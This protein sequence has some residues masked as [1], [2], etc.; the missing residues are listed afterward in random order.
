M[1]VAFEPPE[2]DALLDLREVAAAAGIT[3]ATARA[4]CLSGRLPSIAGPA[5][6]PLVMRSDLDLWL[7][8]RGQDGNRMR[9]LRD[10]KAGAEALRRLA[11][12][13]SGQLDL[14]ALF[15]DVIAD[16]MDL[17]SLARMGLWLY[18]ANRSNPFSLAAQHG[19]TDEI[20][21]WVSSLGA[22]APAAGVQAIQTR[23]VVTLADTLL[24]TPTDDVR[25][26]YRRNGIRSVCFAPMIFRDE[27]LGLLVLYQDAVHAW[28]DEETALARGIADQVAT[29]VGNARLNDSVRGLAARLEA[30]QELAVRLNRTRGLAEIGDLII[31]GTERLI[32][33]DSIRVYRIDH[34]AGMCVP[35][36]FRGQFGGSRQPDP[37]VL[38]VA[39]GQG[40]TGWVAEQNETVVT[41]D[42]AADPRSVHRFISIAPESML[43]V[44]IS[45]EDH[46]HG[47]IAVSAIG[48]DRFG[49]QDETTLTIF[50]SYAAQAIVHANQLDQ[51]DRQHRELEHQLASQRRLLEI[52]ERLIS[53]RDPKGILEMI[54]DSLRAIVPYDSM[55][56]YRCDFEAGVRRAVVARDRF[57]EVILD[58]A[59]P[60]AGGLSGWVVAHGEG[61]LVNDAL[62]DPRSIQVPGTPP[63][64][65]AMI[66]V[67]VRVAGAVVG[68]LNVSR[69]GGEEAHFSQN[70]FEL[71]QLFAGQASL[72]LENAEVH[73]AITVR[74]EHDALTGLRNH[75]S[76]QREL[77]HAVAASEGAPFALLMLDLDSFKGFNDTC[78]HP[79]GDALL[80]GVGD[81]MRGAT[82]AGDALYRYGGDE[83][84]VILPGASRIDAFEV[85]ERV[86]RGVA[87]LP[88]PTGPRVA[89]SAGVACYPDDG[90][91]KD[92]LV[93][94]ADQSLYLAKPASRS[95]DPDA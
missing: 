68:T 39:I 47:V 62:A 88:T 55:T 8:R 42:A 50:A 40:L 6:E 29:A 92:E 16:A 43:V 38:Q 76:F 36:A 89:I 81:A 87:N 19:L 90:Q 13:I 41:G 27:P 18:H 26:L 79:A 14:D 4:W 25:D 59:G 45:Y 37:S 60:I 66:V 77:G 33:V 69:V 74:A 48:R 91:T 46:V 10:P 63:E 86:R 65:E 95:E 7:A 49:E 71:V 5:D 3:R 83:F 17:F 22:N 9:V 20:L 30:V 56:I 12:E 31:E 67:P 93:A 73:G 35:I 1:A 61:L 23:E 75:G 70:E 80:A 21:G 52:N 94:A 58:Y 11:A 54:A 72:A 82:R 15:E 51:L 84:A 85:V 24:D 64:A 53:T 57:A 32:E 28:S 34:E 2:P 78:G 44:P